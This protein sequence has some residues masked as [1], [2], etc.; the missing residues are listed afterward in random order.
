MKLLIFVLMPLIIYG[1]EWYP[2]DAEYTTISTF[3]DNSSSGDTIYV[4]ADTVI[5]NSRLEITKGVYLIGSGRLTTVIKS[6]YLMNGS[7]NLENTDD[8]LISYNPA[9]PESNEPFRLSA[10]TFDFDNKCGGIHLR[11]RTTIGIFNIRIDNCD[12]RNAAG[13]CIVIYG[14]VY[15]VID[16]NIL[17]GNA[18]DIDCYGLQSDS[19]ETFT[20]TFGTESNMYYE[21]NIITTTD[22]PHSGGKGGRYC[23]RYNIY[24]HNDD[25]NMYPW[26]D[27]HGNQESGDY[28]TM[29]AEIYGNELTS[30]Y[31]KNYGMFD[32]RG[33]MAMIWG[34][35]IIT[36]GSV[37]AKA[38]EETDDAITPPA[39]GPSGQP[40]HVSSSYYWNNTK[41]SDTQI[42]AIEG[43]DCCN[44]IA[45]DSEFFNYNA[46]FDGSSG[47]GV[48]LYANMPTSN[49][50]VGIGYWATDK[51]GNWNLKNET[52]ND[53]ALYKVT[54]TNTWEL[55]YIPYT[56]PHPL[57]TPETPLPPR[58]LRI[59]K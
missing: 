46:S 17:S 5:W 19:W 58:N 10:M 53:G 36:S 28:A 49:L 20:F 7:Y 18:K 4:P 33:G 48:G 13:R 21:N 52:D 51:G 39:T 9:N 3:I 30:S 12:L 29:G 41:N 45:E 54:A 57:R 37:S 23:S 27:M 31:N 38:R 59:I 32:Q 11:N 56:Y 2:S 1:T 26:Y 6:Q 34:N 25:K 40:Q 50:S 44:A 42:L 8:H 15:G 22:T 47:V 16:N 24:I 43:G 55:Y 35:N 14:T